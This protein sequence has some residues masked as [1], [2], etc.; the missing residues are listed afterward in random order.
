MLDP[1][2]KHTLFEKNLVGERLLNFLLNSN[3]TPTNFSKNNVANKMEGSMNVYLNIYK[4]HEGYLM[5]KFK[6]DHTRPSDYN[7]Q[8]ILNYS[9]G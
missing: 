6:D 4:S 1:F 8:D 7:P 5:M 3:K 9:Q 2:Y